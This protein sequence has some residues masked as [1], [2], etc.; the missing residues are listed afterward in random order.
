M[1]DSTALVWLSSIQALTGKNLEKLLAAFPE[2]GALWDEPNLA[3]RVLIC[4][5][6][7][8]KKTFAR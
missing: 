8:R 7:S 1:N 3:L 6:R 2:P 4:C 5:A